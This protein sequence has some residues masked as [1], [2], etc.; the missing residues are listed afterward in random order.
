MTETQHNLTKLAEEC[1]EVAQRCTKAI[2]FGMD[3]VQPEQSLTNA[4]RIRQEMAGLQAAYEKL[5]H[6][7][8]LTYPSDEEI[9]TASLKQD[10]YFEYSKKVGMVTV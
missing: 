8:L 7:G 1:V 9:N 2:R 3:E 6:R 4:D 5:V 10:K